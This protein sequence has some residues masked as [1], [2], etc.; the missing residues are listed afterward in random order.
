MIL[1]DRELLRLDGVK[2]T[3]IMTLPTALNIYTVVTPKM[4]GDRLYFVDKQRNLL[5]VDK[6]NPSKIVSFAASGFPDCQSESFLEPTNSIVYGPDCFWVSV[7]PD[8]NPSLLKVTA[9]DQFRLALWEGMTLV[10]ALN[11]RITMPVDAYCSAPR[12]EGEVFIAG[13]QC[14][15]RMDAAGFRLICQLPQ[16]HRPLLAPRS[17]N[18]L[19]DGGFLLGLDKG[20]LLVKKKNDSEYEAN[21]LDIGQS[22]VLNW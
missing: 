6:K 11:K 8:P 10:N 3:S 1:T 19:R 21:C 5:F 20:V 7:G 12:S 22:S 18:V 9:D 4:L 14:I 16:M 2:W 15:Y 17:L 13:K